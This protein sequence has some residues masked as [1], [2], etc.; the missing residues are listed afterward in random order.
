MEPVILVFHYVAIKIKLKSIIDHRRKMCDEPYLR[1]N[2][3]TEV[4]SC[5]I[6][7][8]VCTTTL[9]RCVKKKKKN[10]PTIHTNIK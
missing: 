8:P 6:R 4:S 10:I 5:R 3:Q 9:K 1:M 7:S 2:L